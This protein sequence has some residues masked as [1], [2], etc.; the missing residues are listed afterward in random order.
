[1]IKNLRNQTI[2]L[3]GIAQAVYLV[4]QIAK[5]GPA[6]Q[7]AMEASIGS[8]LKIDAENVEDVYGG[9]EGIATGLQQLKRQLGGRNS[10]DPEQAGYAATLVFLEKK[11]M[12]HEKMLQEIRIGAEKA[13]AQAEHSSVLHENVLTILADVYQ[14]TISTIPPRMMIKGNPLY[15]NDPENGNKIRALLLA[16]IR[17]AVLWRQAGGARWRFLF[18]RGK[19]LDECNRLIREA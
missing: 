1:M 8:V 3:A 14:N 12:K 18:L 16:G 15:L 9:L 5:R 2:A 17:S 19:L 6:E 13:D 10:L 11:L 7:S 4:Q